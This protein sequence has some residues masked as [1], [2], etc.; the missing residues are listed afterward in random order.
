[1]LWVSGLFIFIIVVLFVLVFYMWRTAMQDRLI[2]QHLYFNNFPEGFGDMRI[3]FISDIHRR[4]IS[5]RLIEG[6]LGKV[7][8]VIIGGDLREGGVPLLRV[9][10]NLLKLK[11]L[12]PLYFV[13]GN[14]DYEGDFH[15]LDATLLK[16]G[17]KILDNTAVSFESQ[18]GKQIAL[19]GIDDITEE[20][21]RLDLALSDCGNEPFRVL[22]SHNPLVKEQLMPEHRIS[23]VLS[24]HT[25]GGQIRLFGF[26]PYQIGGIRREGNCL[27]VTSNGYGTSAVP[28]RL[29]ARPETH[30]FTLKRGKRTE[31]GEAVE[32]TY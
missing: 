18:N 1:M 29:E 15:E 6:A 20:R 21:D 23:L 12:G 17:V 4:I 2:F 22:V 5:D 3:F 25:H 28:L 9:E 7:D 8:L 31:M 26:G 27:Y 30:L 32:K 24:G 14:N 13:W 19:L 10:K 16:H 11:E